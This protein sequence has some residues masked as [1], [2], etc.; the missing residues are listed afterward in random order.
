MNAEAFLNISE[1]AKNKF[2]TENGFTKRLFRFNLLM[3]KLK[4][5]NFRFSSLSF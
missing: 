1:T 5:L 3:S 2:E 4:I